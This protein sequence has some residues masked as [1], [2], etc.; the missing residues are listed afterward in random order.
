MRVPNP[1]GAVTSAGRL[2]GQVEEARLCC[3]TPLQLILVI[4]VRP[5]GVSSSTGGHTQL[6]DRTWRQQ[7]EDSAAG[8][9][10]Q[11]THGTQNVTLWGA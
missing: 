8:R 11:P 2:W 9:G 5:S 1:A 4:S 7:G 3:R 6:R 10:R